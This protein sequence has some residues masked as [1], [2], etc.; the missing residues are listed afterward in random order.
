M[1][2]I[3]EVYNQALEDTNAIQELKPLG[4]S[5]IN[6]GVKIVVEVEITFK[7]VMRKNINCF[8]FTDGKREE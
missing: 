6:Y 4:F 7:N 8:L 3:E 1:L 2:S 5:V